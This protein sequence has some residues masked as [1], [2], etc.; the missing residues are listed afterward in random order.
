MIRIIAKGIASILLEIATAT[1]TIAI[2]LLVTSAYITARLV[3]VDWQLGRI[4][5][6]VKVARDLLAVGIS[7]KRS[8]GQNDQTGTVIEPSETVAVETV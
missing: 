8:Q 1:L 4:A 2:V 3:G 7:A 5:K 6:M